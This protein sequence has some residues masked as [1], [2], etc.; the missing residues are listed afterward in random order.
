[1]NLLICRKNINCGIT[2]SLE[3]FREVMDAA[4]KANIPVRGLALC[5]KIFAI[6]LIYFSVL[7]LLFWFLCYINELT[8][9]HRTLYFKQQS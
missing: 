5:M 1:M 9:T 7:M 6:L 3:R 4:K 2:E 8:S